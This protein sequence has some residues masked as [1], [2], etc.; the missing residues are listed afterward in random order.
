MWLQHCAPSKG[1]FQHVAAIDHFE[2]IFIVLDKEDDIGS[3]SCHQNDA[4]I[5]SAS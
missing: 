3:G 1:A 4:K 2:K 5:G